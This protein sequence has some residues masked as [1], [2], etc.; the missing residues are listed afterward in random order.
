MHPPHIIQTKTQKNTGSQ[1][2]PCSCLK[3]HSLISDF[4]KDI[5]RYFQLNITII[6]N[7]YIVV[8]IQFFHNIHI[9]SNN[10]N[11]TKSFQTIVLITTK[12]PFFKSVTNNYLEF[13]TNKE[14]YIALQHL[15]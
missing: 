11:N 8:I 9:F 7:N 5:F 10:C 3:G 12:E 4:K 2:L 6:N 14:E 15:T 1:P 13:F